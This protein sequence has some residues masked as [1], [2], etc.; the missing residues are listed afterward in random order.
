[1]RTRIHEVPACLVETIEVEAERYNLIRLALSRLGG[2]LRFPLVGLRNLDIVLQRDCWV[3]VD[4]SAL[5]LP[6]AA[7]NRFENQERLALNADVR[8]ELRHYQVNTDILLPYMWMTMEGILRGRL[9][10]E[11]SGKSAQ[12]ISLFSH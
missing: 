9:S 6:V 4:R 12:L 1:M 2:P 5:D 11:R 8:C 7:W 10:R 3:C